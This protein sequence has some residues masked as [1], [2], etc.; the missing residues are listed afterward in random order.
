MFT[1]GVPEMGSL[2]LALTNYVMAYA[3]DRSGFLDDSSVNMAALNRL[4]GLGMT[5]SGVAR[6]RVLITK[7]A[8]DVAE[9]LKR[10]KRMVR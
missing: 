3:F 7:A 5:D 10:A 4:R 2:V 9:E 8:T 6:L 1:H